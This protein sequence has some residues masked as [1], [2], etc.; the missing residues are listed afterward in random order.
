MHP[1]YP[2]IVYELDYGYLD[3]TKS[4][5]NEGI[6]VWLGTY[7]KQKLD[8]IDFS[9][10]FIGLD[11]YIMNAELSLLKENGCADSVYKIDLERENLLDVLE[12]IQSRQHKLNYYSLLHE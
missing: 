1:R 8:A 7:A 2:Q 4:S 10:K 3:G 11:D 5:D 12:I 6:D 9:S